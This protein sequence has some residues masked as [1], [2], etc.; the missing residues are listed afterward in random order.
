[1]DPETAK[2]AGAIS[3][4]TAVTISLIEAFAKLADGADLPAEFLAE[5]FPSLPAGFLKSVPQAQGLV[6]ARWKSFHLKICG[7][8]LTQTR[9][10]VDWLDGP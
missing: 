10:Q 6:V 1:M 4:E 7:K 2:K 8:L 5:S 3:L 9:S